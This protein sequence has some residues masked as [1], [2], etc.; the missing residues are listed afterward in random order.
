[1]HASQNY[2]FVE[3]NAIELLPNCKVSTAICRTMFFKSTRTV[4]VRKYMYYYDF[5]LNSRECFSIMVNYNL[6][7]L[8]IFLLLF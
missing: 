3:K 2:H 7:M 4:H 1:M 5:V 6:I 8:M